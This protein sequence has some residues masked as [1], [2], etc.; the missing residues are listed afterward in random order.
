MRISHD[1]LT[2]EKHII[3]LLKGMRR[4]KKITQSELANRIDVSRD[5]IARIESGKARVYMAQVVAI[6]KALDIALQDL[7]SMTMEKTDLA[8]GQKN[9][10]IADI[11]S[12]YYKSTNTFEPPSSSSRRIDIFKDRE[13]NNNPYLNEKAVESYGGPMKD[14]IINHKLFWHWVPENSLSGLSISSVVEAAL[15]LGNEQDI[16]D[17]F[18]MVDIKKVSEIFLQ[19]ILGPRTN[20]REETISFF[21]AYFKRHVPEYSD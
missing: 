12:G 5:T 7:V 15:S 11:P 20:Y 6:A 14:Y 8:T 18:K 9:T 3:M 17:L 13:D 10:S 2:F 19:G 4:N 21:D 16:S 1:P